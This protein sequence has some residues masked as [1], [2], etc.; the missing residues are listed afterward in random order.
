[1]LKRK[2]WRVIIGYALKGYGIEKLPLAFEKNYNQLC[3]KIFLS[4]LLELLLNFLSRNK[5]VWLNVLFW[6]MAASSPQS[7]TSSISVLNL[8]LCY[9]CRNILDTRVISFTGF[10]SGFFYFFLYLT[11]TS[12]FPY[13]PLPLSLPNSFLQHFFLSQSLVFSLLLISSIPHSF[14]I[15]LF[16]NERFKYNERVSFWH[17]RVV[18]SSET[19]S[20]KFSRDVNFIATACWA[21]NVTLFV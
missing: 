18:Y 5:R 2:P 1:M 10:F 14:S 21:Q 12:I 3:N 4:F 6:N 20:L 17:F 16:P 11:F 19:K 15:A 9:P 7:T 8:D 13:P